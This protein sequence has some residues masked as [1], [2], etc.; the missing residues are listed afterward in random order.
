[1]PKFE[2]K[3]TEREQEWSSD[4]APLQCAINI[5]QS[6]APDTPGLAGGAHD[7]PTQST[8]D[9][10]GHGGRLAPTRCLGVTPGYGEGPLSPLSD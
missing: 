8:F 10:P 6:S 3:V 4:N 9:T 2:L 5:T 7:A 1:M